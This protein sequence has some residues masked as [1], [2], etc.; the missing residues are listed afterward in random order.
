MQSGLLLFLSVLLMG[1]AQ[2]SP[3]ENTFTTYSWDGTTDFELSYT[4][5]ADVTDLRLTLVGQ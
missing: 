2:A 4:F 3:A 1:I 5:T